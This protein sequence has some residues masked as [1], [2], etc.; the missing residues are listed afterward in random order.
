MANI[1]TYEQPEV[2]YANKL[3]NH[4]LKKK[5]DWFV[6]MNIIFLTERILYSPKYYEI[7]LGGI[8]RVKK[9]W[10]EE[11]WKEYNFN[12]TISDF[13]EEDFEI[14]HIVGGNF[15]KEFN[16]E[17]KKTLTLT[18]KRQVDRVVWGDLILRTKENLEESIKRI[19]KEEI[20]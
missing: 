15:A 2:I 4:I 16:D 11:N 14:G 17:L 3:I 12:N 6:E 10:Y 5:Y 7:I 13:N 1:Y 8:I 19:L 18:M 20:K 9:G